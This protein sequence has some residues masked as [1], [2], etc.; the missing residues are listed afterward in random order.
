MFARFFEVESFFFDDFLGL[1]LLLFE[2]P[3]LETDGF[4]A[5]PFE[6]WL[7][8]GFEAGVVVFL[9]LEAGLFLATAPLLLLPLPLTFFEGEEEDSLFSKDCSLR[10][11]LSNSDSSLSF[12]FS[13]FASRALS[14]ALQ[15][16]AATSLT[17]PSRTGR[18]AGFSAARVFATL[19]AFFQRLVWK[20]F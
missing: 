5:E 11:I 1:P 17:T 16:P 20:L 3:F 7:F 10:A 15:V 2:F 4:P 9:F 12:S 8:F 19:A 18:G 6:F 13:R 14:I